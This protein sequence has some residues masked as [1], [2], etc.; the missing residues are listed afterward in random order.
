MRSAAQVSRTPREYV[1]HQRHEREQTL[2]AL[3]AELRRAC[4]RGDEW[5]RWIAE[6]RPLLTE[7]EYAA[8]ARGSTTRGR[9]AAAAARA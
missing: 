3:L 7:A 1:D 2:A 5:Y 6:G 8:V 4:A 9:R